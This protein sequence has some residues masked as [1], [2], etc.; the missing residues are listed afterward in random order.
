MQVEDINVVALEPRQAPFERL[1]YSVSNATTVGDRQPHFR[2]DKHICGPQASQ[3]AA[4][5]PFRLAV[6]V[7][8]RRVE[9]VD[10]SGEGACNGALL[11]TRIAAH[12]QPANCTTAKT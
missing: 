6:A 11:V 7:L 12:H 10:A 9:V 1:G 3:N 5:I 4:E 2:T 8:H